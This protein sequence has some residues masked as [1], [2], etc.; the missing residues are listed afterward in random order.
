[1][2]FGP[3]H[4]RS[5][6]TMGFYVEAENDQEDEVLLILAK[7]HG[8]D[9]LSSEGRMTLSFALKITQTMWNL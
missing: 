1:M 7:T 9:I 5:K 3:V 6:L 2:K 4:N 8:V